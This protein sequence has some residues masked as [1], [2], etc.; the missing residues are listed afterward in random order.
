MEI[1]KN[2]FLLFSPFNRNVGNPYQFGIKSQKDFEDFLIR[3]NGLNDCSASVYAD[4]GV[5]DKI[6]FD[7]D[8]EGAIE[9]AKK[10][11]DYLKFLECKVI[12]VISGKKGIHLHLLVSSTI[13]V[14]E[15]DARVQLMDACQSIIR[16]GLGIKDWKQKT[17]LDWSKLGAI[18]STCR[19]PNTLRPPA[20]TTW[21][22][23][24]PE[25]WSKLSNNEI[26]DYAKSS[27]DFEYTG[28]VYNLSFFIDNIKNS[29]GFSKYVKRSNEY[30]VL[31]KSTSLVLSESTVST[32]KIPDDLKQFLEPL[33]R[34]CLFRHIFRANPGNDVRV[35]AT[36]DFVDSGLS[37]DQIL[38]IYSR[39]GWENFNEGITR[40]K[41][42]YIADRIY[43][44]DLQAYSCSK[45]RYLQIPR[46][47]CYD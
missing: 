2:T 45:L 47:C 20:N 14:N 37:V 5:I 23:Y 11:Y 13:S 30:N 34:P 10:L 29:S 15:Y 43:N 46:L 38:E 17:T 24:L 9:E 36:I 8:G 21:C 42:E 31:S 26:W 22:S 18:T 44:K 1:D 41:V 39:L 28:E 16:N 6:W 4:D 7:F 25:D 33:M 32:Y 12:P 19:I 40:E 35:A 27:H 3:N